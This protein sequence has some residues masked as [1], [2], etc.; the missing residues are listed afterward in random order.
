MDH[1]EFVARRGKKSDIFICYSE[2]A[3]RV[4]LPWHRVSRRKFDSL[5]NITSKAC[6]DLELPLITALLILDDN[7]G[8]GEDFYQIATTLGR[9]DQSQGPDRFWVSELDC[10][11]RIW[12]RVGYP[13]AYTSKYITTDAAKHYWQLLAADFR[14]EVNRVEEALRLRDASARLEEAESV[15][16]LMNLHEFP[17]LIVA[18]HAFVE[19]EDSLEQLGIAADRMV[20]LIGGSTRNADLTPEHSF[21]ADN[22]GLIIVPDSALQ[23]ITVLSSFAAKSI[24][25]INTAI[26]GHFETQMADEV[27]PQK[28]IHEDDA[29][30]L[31]AL[32]R[33]DLLHRRMDDPGPGLGFKLDERQ[34]ETASLINFYAN[35][36][37]FA[38]EASHHILEHRLNNNTAEGTRSPEEEQR[39]ESEAD[40]LALDIMLANE[41][42]TTQPV[43]LW[44]ALVAILAVDIGERGLLIRQGSTHPNPQTRIVDLM[45]RAAHLPS[46]LLLAGSVQLSQAVDLATNFTAHFPHVGWDRIDADPEI[47]TDLLDWDHL[48][49]VAQIDQMQSLG[50]P[51][52]LQFFERLRDLGYVDLTEGVK[53]ALNGQVRRALE[54]W[55][56]SRWNVK[57]I[58]DPNSALAYSSLHAAIVECSALTGMNDA[59]KMTGTPEDLYTLKSICA[60]AATTVLARKIGS[61]NVS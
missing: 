24:D 35:K 51:E 26:L 16:S 22:S 7:S 36:F 8:P 29:Y 40:Q 59:G 50:D 20:N 46:E 48:E 33:Y 21:Q 52:H 42:P 31:A 54:E 60:S 32:L 57:H 28:L 45:R 23:L 17:M 37:V 10:V 5:L 4:A 1:L 56:V 2:L 47:R 39:L 14:L 61:K 38:H 53:A 43:A 19:I 58:L 18:Y 27:D 30:S 44:G 11:H 34:E 41:A 15:S 13:V 25:S 12:R 9:K 55:G 49:A 6:I 3:R